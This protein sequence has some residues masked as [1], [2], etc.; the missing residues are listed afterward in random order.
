MAEVREDLLNAY[1][2]QEYPLERLV[3]KTAVKRD[4]SRNPLFDTMFSLRSADWENIVLDDFT[5]ELCP[6]ESKTSKLDLAVEAVDRGETISLT[7]EYCTD[8]FREETVRR[9]LSHFENLLKSIAEKPSDKLRDL[10]ILSDAERRQ[11][12][13]EFNDT[14]A[15]YPRDKTVHQIFEEQAELTPLNVAL[16]FNDRKM[17]YG[18]LNARANRLARTLRARGVGPDS[19]V[20][21]M[22]DRSFEMIVAMLGTLK[23]GGAYM[24]IDPEYPE[25]RVA[26][27]LENSGAVLL[28]TKKGLKAPFDGTILCLDD[29]SVYDSDAA[30]LPNINHA[31]DLVYIIY[32]S[33]STGRPKGRHDRT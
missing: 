31:N 1:E 11:L 3:E 29:D 6:L 18:E 25:D 30:N 24:P 33:G 9:L 12:L 15:D 8:L 2:N 16:V 22:V 14:A 4:V 20:G 17:T 27:M 5:A 23:A 7:I 13:Y 19:V 32:T 26:Y 10:V 28:L 21:L